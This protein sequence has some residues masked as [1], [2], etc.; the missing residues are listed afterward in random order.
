MN[1]PVQESVSSGTAAV[2]KA[3]HPKPIANAL[4]CAGVVKMV[5]LSPT[6]L[7][8]GLGLLVASD[9]GLALGA[10]LYERR[11]A[12]GS[13][14]GP[15]PAP[16]RLRSPRRLILGFLPPLIGTLGMWGALSRSFAGLAVALGLGS[17][18]GIGLAATVGLMG[19]I[20]YLWTGRSVKVPAAP[21][22]T[23]ILMPP[24]PRTPCTDRAA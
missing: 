24:P 21:T 22:Q 16:L 3:T 19:T 1:C 18:L 14:C 23:A 4:S 13:S 9:V 12:G 11:R 20:D 5:I 2:S 8:Y 10:R 17:A 15:V 6:S 7:G